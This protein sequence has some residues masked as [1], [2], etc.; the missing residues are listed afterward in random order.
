MITIQNTKFFT[1]LEIAKELNITP[2]TVRTYIKQGRLKGQR[3]GRPY[4]ISEDSL[5]EF[6]SGSGATPEIKQKTN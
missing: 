3:V 1:V 5:R 4:L 6:L 2:I